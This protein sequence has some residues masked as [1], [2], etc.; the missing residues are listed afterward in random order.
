MKKL[1]LMV[2]GV[3]LEQSSPAVFERSRSSS[4]ALRIVL[5]VPNDQADLLQRLTASLPPP[6]FVLYVLH[7]PRGEAEPGRYQS[8]ELARDQL[9]ALLSKY[10]EFLSSDGR[11][12]IWIHSPRSGQTVVWDRHNQLFAEGEPLD[13]FREVLLASG[14][15][16][17]SVEPLGAHAHYYRAEFDVDAAGLLTE[18]DWHR[19]PLRPEDERS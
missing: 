5:S 10:R 19:T 1:S 4:G 8:P 15:S 2:D 7:T 6:F 11:H 12:D 16:E 13:I 9:D 17:G 18:L 3:A 14:F